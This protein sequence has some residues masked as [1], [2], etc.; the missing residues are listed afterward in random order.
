MIEWM[1][2]RMLGGMWRMWYWR[3]WS[4]HIDTVMQHKKQQYDWTHKV[5][6]QIGIYMLPL[7]DKDMIHKSI[8]NNKK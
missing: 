2:E 3:D 4:S 8:E 7:N 5:Y 6:T 1:N